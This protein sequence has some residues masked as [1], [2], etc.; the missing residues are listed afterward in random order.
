ME[1]V[2]LKFIYC[3]K[4]EI[5]GGVC[6]YVACMCALNDSIT[7]LIILKNDPMFSGN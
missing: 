7:C 4:E 2:N 5:G 3:N 6:V 1:I